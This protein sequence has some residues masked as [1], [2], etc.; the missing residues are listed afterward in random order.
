MLQDITAVIKTFERPNELDRLIQSLRGFYPDLKIIVADDSKIPYP[1]NDVE[2][3]VMPYDRGISVGRNLLIQKV[4]TKYIALF[5]DDFVATAQTNLT[6][7][8][9]LLEQSGLDIMAGDVVNEGVHRQYF[10][11]TYEF[12]LGILFQHF[13]KSCGLLGGFPLYEVVLNFFVARTEAIRMI[14]W[15]EQIKFGREHADFFLRCR[16]QLKISR[17]PV[18]SVDHFPGPKKYEGQRGNESRKHFNRKW[19]VITR[20]GIPENIRHQRLWMLKQTGKAYGQFLGNRIR[21]N[22]IEL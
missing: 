17:L 22:E 21:R 8:A 7:M 10:H 18:F 4:T 11:G 1:R 5:D 19:R 12:C 16:S 13:G 15:D 9:A 14:L 2:Y 20:I 3:H 6:Q